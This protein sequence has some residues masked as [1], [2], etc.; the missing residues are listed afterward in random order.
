MMKSYPLTGV[1]LNNFLV[2]LPQFSS[3]TDRIRSLQPAHNFYLLIGAETGILGLV[4]LLGLLIFTSKKIFKKQQFSNLAMKQF[5]PPLV[6]SFGAILF[7]GLFDHYF[8]TLQ[9]GQLLAILIFGLVFAS[10]DKKQASA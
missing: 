6:I 8:Y 9:Q 7:L 5:H 1:G 10:F 2:R 4:A 3:A